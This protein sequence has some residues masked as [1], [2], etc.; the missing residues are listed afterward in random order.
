MA[1]KDLM[2]TRDFRVVGYETSWEGEVEDIRFDQLTH[3]NYAFL[4]PAADGSGELLP[5]ENEE[6]LL[7]LVPAAHAR[8]VKAQDGAR[9]SARRG[10][11]GLVP[12]SGHAR[13][14]LAANG[15]PRD[16]PRPASITFAVSCR[17]ALERV[18]KNTRPV[19]FLYLTPVAGLN[20]QP[21][22][23]CPQAERL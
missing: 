14:H 21:A 10:R 1:T 15:H 7:Q 5:V 13:R 9:P 12:G 18:M 20:Q 23:E 2:L 3:I 8:G 22:H 19:E 6:K 17:G 11:D 16:Q 4:L